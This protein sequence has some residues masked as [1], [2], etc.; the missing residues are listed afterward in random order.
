M[1]WRSHHTSRWIN[2]PEK[3]RDKLVEVTAENLFHSKLTGEPLWSHTL[4]VQCLGGKFHNIKLELPGKITL[5]GHPDK[6]A[7]KTMMGLGGE[8]PPCFILKKN[9][10]NWDQETLANRPMFRAFCIM[11]QRVQEVHAKMR[12][13]YIDLL[14]PG[15]VKPNEKLR[16]RLE[17]RLCEAFEDLKYR[18]HKAWKGEKRYGLTEPRDREPWEHGLSVILTHKL[19]GKQT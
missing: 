5:L 14:D 12:N 2:L 7:E 6:Q 16:E 1:S 3:Y 9:L 13:Q 18:T 19:K 10:L 4:K 17:A 11:R 15:S 8:E